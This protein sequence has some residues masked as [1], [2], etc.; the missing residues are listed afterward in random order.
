MYCKRWATETFLEINKLGWMGRIELQKS[1]VDLHFSDVLVR[2]QVFLGRVLPAQF[3]LHPIQHQ[4]PPCLFVPPESK[5]SIDCR[6]E[7][8][9]IV[10]GK[11]ETCSLP[12][13]GII[14]QDSIG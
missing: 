13:R 6:F 2:N 4:L 7:M 11:D 3:L 12:C 14:F 5:G 9:W 8:L 1:E 10:A